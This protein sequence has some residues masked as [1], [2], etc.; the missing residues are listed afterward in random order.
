MV[1]LVVKYRCPKCGKVGNLVMT[2]HKDRQKGTFF[3]RIRMIHISKTGRKEC[4][5]ATLR[6]S[7]SKQEESP[8]KAK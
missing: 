6:A 1:K 8:R 5:L 2:E 3:H 7:K 4:L